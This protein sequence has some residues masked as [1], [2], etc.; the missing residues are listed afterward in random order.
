VQVEARPDWVESIIQ[1]LEE[2]ILPEDRKE[3]KK[4]QM[5]VARHTLIQGILYKRGQTLPLLKCVA[6]KEGAYI[7][8]EIH[9]GVCSSHA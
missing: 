8:K 9:E 5:K 6:K 2:G 4:L 7:L 1:F 3:A